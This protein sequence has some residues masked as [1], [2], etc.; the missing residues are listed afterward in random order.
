MTILAVNSPPYPSSQPLEMFYSVLNIAMRWV[1]LNFYYRKLPIYKN[2]LTSTLHV[3]ISTESIVM[4]TWPVL[5][6]LYSLLTTPFP[7]ILKQISNH[8]IISSINILYVTP[9]DNNSFQNTVLTGL[10]YQNK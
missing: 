7:D 3:P 5:F 2:S 10:F 4:N 9:T 8:Y 6:Y 1:F